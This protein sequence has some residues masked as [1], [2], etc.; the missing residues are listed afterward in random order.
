MDF[1][2]VATAAFTEYRETLRTALDG[3]TSSE[4]RWQ[5]SPNSNHALFLTWHIA[6]VE[7]MWMTRY[8]GGQDEVWISG[9]WCEALRLPAQ[10][11][12]YG[13]SMEQIASFPDLDIERILGYFD[14][15]H[16]STLQVVT[17]LTDEDLG[18]NFPGRHWRDP[19]G[20]D[21]NG[22]I[23]H[24]IIEAS[25]HVGQVAFIRGMLRGLNN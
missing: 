14:A 5:P 22:V 15:V 2:D 10:G 9:R 7:D 20:P 23:S 16:E 13:M 21:V 11:N 6:R 19:E 17:S 18:K 25:E 12:G 8:V 24:L 4:L 1:R 3:L